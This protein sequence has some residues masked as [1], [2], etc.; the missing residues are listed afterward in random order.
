MENSAII[1]AGE[2]SKRSGLDKGL[3]MLAD[4]PLILYVVDNVSTAI[5]EILVVVSSKSQEKDYA[6]ILKSKA[7]IIIDKNETQ[8]PL[9]GALTG[10]E[11]VHSEYSLLLP[12][13]TP[14]VSAPIISLLL[15][16]CVNKDAAIPRWVKGYLEPLQAAYHTKS[17]LT[18]ANMALEDN[19]MKMHSMIAC[20]KKVRY[21]STLVLKQMDPTLMT[22]FNVNT[23]E[24][25]RKAE[26]MLLAA[27]ART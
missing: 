22:F 7:K 21:V 6:N 23:P 8:S 12:C 14:F 4:K 3:L 24:D 15:Q 20:L 9:V 18:A 2:F 10:F 11:S 25:L 13:D 5:D 16:L 1:L 27:R 19:K 17:A 26:Y